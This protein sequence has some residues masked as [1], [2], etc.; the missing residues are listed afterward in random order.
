MFFC[1]FFFVTETAMI[2]VARLRVILRKSSSE[3]VRAAAA[4]LFATTV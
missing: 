4:L 3:S 1:L 2:S